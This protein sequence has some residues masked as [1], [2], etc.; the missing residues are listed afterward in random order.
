MLSQMLPSQ[1]SSGMHVSRK[2]LTRPTEYRLAGVAY[3][4]GGGDNEDAIEFCAARVAAGGV[5]VLFPKLGNCHRLQ[6]VYQA[7][8][9]VMHVYKVR[10]IP[11]IGRGT[12]TPYI[13]V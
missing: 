13:C 1:R 8:M 5:V 4:R 3:K 9:N 10:K 7:A 12:Q 2:P 11:P 6:S